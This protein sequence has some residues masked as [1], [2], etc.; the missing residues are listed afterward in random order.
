MPTRS[1]SKYNFTQLNHFLLRAVESQF[2]RWSLALNTQAI[3][4]GGEKQI[5]Q[6]N[7]GLKTLIRCKN[8][9]CPELNTEN[10]YHQN[11]LL[12]HS[13]KGS[14][15]TRIAD[16]WMCCWVCAVSPWL[17]CKLWESN[18]SIARKCRHSS[19]RDVTTEEPRRWSR[20]VRVTMADI[21]GQHWEMICGNYQHIVHSVLPYYISWK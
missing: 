20:T 5:L 14:V 19:S 4:Q 8:F 7:S 17:T 13:G 15:K 2:C 9:F 21:H 12:V 10:P 1:P 3:L 16:D 18:E 11:W 6:G